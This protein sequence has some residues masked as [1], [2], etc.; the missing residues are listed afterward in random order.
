MDE[1]GLTKTFMLISNLK[2]KSVAM[3]YTKLFQCFKALSW[4]LRQRFRLQLNRKG[5]T[6]ECQREIQMNT[7]ENTNE[8]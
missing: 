6:N 2:K 8:S 4:L 3:V 5:R 1:K 7:K